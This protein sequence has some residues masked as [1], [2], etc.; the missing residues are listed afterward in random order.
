MKKTIPIILAA[1]ILVA[2][3]VAA[4]PAQA[5]MIGAPPL[6]RF[7]GTFYPP[8]QKGVWDTNTLRVWLRKKEMLFKVEGLKNVTGE[9]DSML[10]M[11][12]LFPPQLVVEGSK[13]LLSRLQQE[14]IS[15]KL[16][17]MEGY[18]YIGNGFFSVQD[19]WMGKTKAK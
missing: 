10:I 19:T 1:I 7:T 15:G 2:S 6:V 8:D 18:L 3:F 13:D 17:T 4:F 9:A 14:E 12:S 5:Q 11:Q 16:V